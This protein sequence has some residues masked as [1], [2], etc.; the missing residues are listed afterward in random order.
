MGDTVGLEVY[1][2]SAPAVELPRQQLANAVRDLEMTSTEE[3]FLDL[4]WRDSENA[5]DAGVDAY[6]VYV[7]AV[8]QSWS[9]A[10]REIVPRTYGRASTGNGSGG[11]PGNNGAGTAGRR[12]DGQDVRH[13]GRLGRIGRP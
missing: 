1:Y 12:R 11:N 7:K 3:G 6:E 5:G 4:S 10:R 8:D 13:A 9:E 2:R